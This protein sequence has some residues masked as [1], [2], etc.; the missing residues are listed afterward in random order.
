MSVEKPGL[1]SYM[2]KRDVKRLLDIADGGAE[3]DLAAGK[4]ASLEDADKIIEERL[5]RKANKNWVGSHW[6]RERMGREPWG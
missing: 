1:Q 2:M 5:R 6:F 4:G 3:E